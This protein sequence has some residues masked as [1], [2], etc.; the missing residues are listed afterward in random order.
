VDISGALKGGTGNT[1]VVEG[2]GTAGAGAVVLIG[3][4]PAA[5]ASG[6]FQVTAASAVSTFIN[7]PALQITQSG[8]QTALSWPATGPAGEDFTAYQL[9]TSA[10]GLPGSWSAAGTAP[11]SAGGQ[12]TVTVTA[13]GSGQ[14]YQLANP[15]AQ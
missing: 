12:L 1:V 9:Q 4:T 13:G 15:A 6:N 11:V 14:F 7:L 5:P 2:F 8:D 10:S 3:E